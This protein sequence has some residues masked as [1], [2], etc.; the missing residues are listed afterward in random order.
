MTTVTLIGSRLA[1]PGTEFVYEGEADG[2]AGCPY[3]SQCLNLS[4]DT[5]YRVTAVREN[6]QT[7]ECAMHDG[8]VR[9]VEVEPASV[10]ANIPS[11]GSFAGSKASL[12]GPCPYVEC[13][14]HEFCEPD[15]VAF[16]EE[17]R[18]SEILGDPPHEVCHL[19]RSLQLVELDLD[20]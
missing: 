13:P 19:D 17:H 11:K 8:G 10:R 5:K 4:S 7:L 3:R 6:A 9:A 18:I 14:S 16:D 1:D 12:S 15:G 20:G 2:C